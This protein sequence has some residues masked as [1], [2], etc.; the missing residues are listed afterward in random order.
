MKDYYKILGVPRDASANEIKKAYKAR[1]LET[2]PDR[3]PNDP[4]AEEKFK[5][6]SEAY[7]ILSDKD[8]RQHYDMGGMSGGYNPGPGFDP[9]SPFD[10][11]MGGGLDE[12]LQEIFRQRGVNAYKQPAQRTSPGSDVGTYVTLSLE[13]V[14]AGCSKT[15]NIQ[16]QI[17]CQTCDGSGAQNASDAM[18]SCSLCGGSGR[19]GRRNGMMQIMMSCSRCNGTGKTVSKPCNDCHGNS[20]KTLNETISVKIPAGV[21]H[22]NMLRIQ[23]KGNESPTKGGPSGNLLVEIAVS[24][25]PIFERDGD[26]LYTELKIPFPI[27]VLGGEITVPVLGTK[28]GDRP[29]IKMTVPQKGISEMPVLEIEDRGLP[30]LRTG[31]RGLQVVR[32]VVHIP[33]SDD[34]SEK[35]KELLKQYLEA[36]DDSWLDNWMKS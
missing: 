30:S 19:I 34:L 22:G 11:G 17:R 28:T 10:F 29:T 35:Q 13:E 16:R 21:H 31:R 23:G 6:I 24:E 33:S 32:L 14:L 7:S 27:A 26:E 9:F 20:T 4:K 36:S 1:A 25:H 3:N 8:K 5:E 18:Q 12:I 2:H 15:V